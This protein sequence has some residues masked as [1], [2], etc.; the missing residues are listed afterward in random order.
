M[1]KPGSPFGKARTVGTKVFLFDLERNRPNG[2]QPIRSNVP[3]FRENILCFEAKSR[4]PFPDIDFCPGMYYYNHQSN[5]RFE[6][7]SPID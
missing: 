4:E 1:E 2:E 6:N 5:T 7:S 3:A